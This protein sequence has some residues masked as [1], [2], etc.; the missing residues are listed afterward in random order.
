MDADAE[1]TK[2][3]SAPPAAVPAP[4]E[5]AARPATGLALGSALAGPME[6]G[7]PA[8]PRKSGLGVGLFVPPPGSKPDSEM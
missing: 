4:S 3:G 6:S 5:D 7:N 1:R 8:P 2:P